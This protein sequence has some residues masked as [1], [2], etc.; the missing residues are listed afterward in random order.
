MSA[1][2]GRVTMNGTG[3]QSLAAATY[4]D[5]TINNSGS[6]VTMAGDVTVGD[7]LQ[8]TSGAFS[9]G[10]NTLTLNNALVRTS[11][12]LTGGT[13]S[14]I[15]IATHAST[16]L[17]LPAITVSNLFV[18]RTPGV[19][20]TGNVTVNDTLQL[21]S[22]ALSIGANT[23]TLNGALVRTSGALTG[24]T[25]SNITIVEN[26]SDEITLPS[27]TLNNLSVARTPGVTTAGNITV[28]GTLTMTSGAIVTG[29]D[30]VTIGSS[31]ATVGNLSY[32]GGK[33]Q[34]NLRRWF[35]TSTVSNVLFPVGSSY[36]YNPATIGFTTAPTTS[37]T[38]TATFKD[39]NPGSQG[40]PLSDGA[41]TVRNVAQNGY[42][43]ISH[44]DGLAGGIYSLDLTA[45]G[46]GGINN[47]ATV[48]IIKR[49]DSTQNWQAPGSHSAGTGTIALPTF[50]RTGLSGFSD[51]GLGSDGDN[52][53]PVELVSFTGQL[54][55]NLVSL[56][57]NTASEVDNH[58]FYVERMVES[59]AATGEWQQIGFQAGHGTTAKPHSYGF[60]DEISMLRLPDQSVTLA[61]RLQQVDEDGTNSYSNIVRIELAPP[62]KRP[63]L[64]E[65]SPNPSGGIATIPYYVP[66][67]SR[68][69][70]ALYDPLGTR[71]RSLVDEQQ[72]T[73][74]HALQL[75]LKDLPSGTYY[76]ALEIGSYR[77][78]RSILLVK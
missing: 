73:G 15:T 61:Y 68:V 25:S 49:A 64:G 77:S 17:T 5:L 50:H 6:G 58:G 8:L 65:S 9:I 31:G 30:T 12:T 7:T 4:S 66:Q 14:S 62:G 24:G 67:A 23:L 10:A 3:A 56:E 36:H 75:D 72:E 20:M 48:R 70:L 35:A 40:T 55:D 45:E 53:L 42:W 1:N 74:E 43:T 13:S 33:I 60:G 57:W 22:G 47:I 78:S 26:L 21:T 52:T 54:T 71:I 34:G 16:N 28:V 44:A 39:W 46:F 37:G 59:D 29:T 27:V 32:T 41:V 18:T 51:F 63:H 69:V 76:Y 19:T 38:L 2:S 11:G